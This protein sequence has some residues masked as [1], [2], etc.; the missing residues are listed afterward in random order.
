MLG[1]ACE[2]LRQGFYFHI[3]MLLEEIHRREV[4]DEYPSFFLCPLV[5]EFY[6][7]VPL[8]MTYT[9]KGGSSFL[10]LWC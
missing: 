1:D 3:K 8:V 5:L 4:R 9:K 2:S 7:H 6:I 10:A